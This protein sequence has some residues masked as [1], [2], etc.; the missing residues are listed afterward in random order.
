MKGV[1]EMKR[2]LSLAALGLSVCLLTS[3]AQGAVLQSGSHAPVELSSWV[4]SWDKDKGLAEYRQFKNHLSSVCCFMAYYDSEDKLFIPEGTREIAAYARK[5][6]HKQRYLT[7]TNDW[8]DEKGWQNPKNKDLLKRLLAN[9]EQKNAVVQEMLAAAKE[10]ECN[11][12]EL[13]YE[14]FFKDKA[15][16]QNYLSFTY[17]LSMA[18]I[19]ENLDLRIVLEPGMPMDAGLCKGP[20]YVVMFYNLQGKHSGPGP[21]ADAEFIQ[22]TITRMNAIPGRKSA[23]FA[24]GG[25]LWEDYGLLGLKKGPIRFVDEDEAADL[26]KKH[27]LI[28]ERDEESAAL[29]C[30][31]EENGHSYELWYADSETINAWIKAA[32]DNGIEQVSLWRLGGNVNIK[33]IKNK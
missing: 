11:G 16:L 9:D 14:A 25:C 3:C 27:S 2:Y 10:L 1:V 15:L 22:K 31:Y 26:V 28:P 21:K 29:H 24:T 20:E 32:A 17:K 19:K 4:A 30:Q 7:I 12:I 6:G 13:D 8:Q 18:C 33:D 23:A 5:E